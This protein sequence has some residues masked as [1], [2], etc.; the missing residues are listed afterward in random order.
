MGLLWGQ[1]FFEM[2]FQRGGVVVF[3]VAGA[4]QQDDISRLSRFEQWTPRF[5]MRIEFGGV[6]PAKFIPARLI[7]SEPF[8]QRVAGRSLLQ[9]SFDLERIL[10]DA[11][12][13]EAI[14]EKTKSVV[15]GWRVVNALDSDQ[16]IS[17]FINGTRLCAHFTPSAESS[18]SRKN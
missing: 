16:G 9:P 8:S 3:E 13:P 12:R 1:M 18:S 15:G 5:G 17:S 4:E 10:P 7:V 11:A 14:H 2:K 6:A